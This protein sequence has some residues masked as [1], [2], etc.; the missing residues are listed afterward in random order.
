LLS[1]GDEH[2][3]AKCWERMRERLGE[4]ASGLLVTHDWSAVIK[5]CESSYIVEAGRV[6]DF[7][8]SDSIVAK[9]LAL[10]QPAGRVARFIDG[11]SRQ[12]T[13]KSLED[14]RIDIRAEIRQPEPVALA[15]S[16]EL[17]RI[18][19]GWEI[20]LIDRNFLVGSKPG[21]YDLI[22][23]VPALPLPMG[24]YSLN[25]WLH[26]LS[27][28]RNSPIGIETYDARSWTFGNGYRLTVKGDRSKAVTIPRLE[29]SVHG[30]G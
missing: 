29:W 12:R 13:A 6:I 4:G 5:L 30:V 25:F 22:I 21:F 8:R 17:L 11:E 19:V 16:V 28:E 26:N 18:G 1:V 23:E 20:L 14:A 9:Y 15:F 24:E 2:F 27:S 3:Q 7:G 10:E